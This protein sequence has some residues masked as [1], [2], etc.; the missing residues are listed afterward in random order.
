M[1]EVW[2]ARDTTLGRDVALK[3]LPD[4]L[5][6]DSDR[7]ARLKREAQILAS[8]NHPNIAAIHGFQDSDGVQ[9]LVLE[10]V[11][12]PTL[13]DRIA[14][15]PI[16]VDEALPIAKQI[17]EALEAAHEQGI[18][19]R[20]LKPANIK[21]RPDGTVK[22]LDFGLAKALE[23]AIS[24]MSPNVTQSPTI[25][26]PAMMT[27]AG[28]ILGTAAYMSPEQ[29]RGHAVDKRTDIW[30]FGCVLFEMV[31]G[32]RAFDGAS[33]T[34]IIASIIKTEPDWTRLPSRASSRTRS[35]L[36]HCLQ[37][38]PKRRLHEI[39]DARF[40]IDEI[41]AEEP[42]A[43]V[44]GAS[45]P[46]KRRGRRAALSVGAAAAVV[47][48]AAAAVVMFNVGGTREGDQPS[49][50]FQVDP[51]DG[52][53]FGIGTITGAT[54]VP[55]PALSP[56]GRYLA[57]IAI[58]EDRRQ[59]LWI[60]PLDSKLAQPVPGSEGAAVP[61]WSPD[62]RY[63]GFF[64]GR[65]LKTVPVSG[66]P[67]QT[68][69]D[70]IDD[71]GATGSWNQDNVIVFSSGTA[72]PGISRVPASGGQPVAITTLNSSREETGHL[73]PHF[74]PDGRHFLFFAQSRDI[75]A[76][77]HDGVYIGSLDAEEPKR[78]LNGAIEAYYAS[79]GYLLFKRDQN[80][81]A[82]PFDAGR[83]E[84]A[85]DAFS[86]ADQVAGNS[87]NGKVALSVSDAGIIAY[88]TGLSLIDRQITWL[89]RAG[90]RVGIVGPLGDYRAL[91]LSDDGKRLALTRLSDGSADIW[92]LDL[93]RGVPTRLTFDPAVD[94]APVW[95][96][97][98]S[99]VAFRSQRNEKTQLYQKLASG[100]GDDDP[101]PNVAG[102]AF[103]HDW[104]SD[105]RFIVYGTLGQGTG[106]DLWV[107]PLSG[108]QK[109]FGF[110]TT[111][112]SE[113]QARLSPDGRWL[114]YSSNESGR[115]EVY[116]QSFPK[117]AGKWQ[118]STDGGAQPRWRGDG[119]ELYYLS[120]TRVMAVPITA[121]AGL[122]VG[123]ATPLFDATFSTNPLRFGATEYDVAA[124]GQRF[125]VSA[126]T[127]ARNTPLT[128]VVNWTARLKN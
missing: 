116:V 92:L 46:A 98:G 109:P 5:A 74:L 19:H 34:D 7:L 78:I 95:S 71:S 81:M 124:D 24:A 108:D 36:R 49:Y 39:A 22:V 110:L 90:N 112:F 38:D 6:L 37:K 73:W 120:S 2:K 104:S 94:N 84:P 16:P 107:L 66:G 83:L 122:E 12:G 35:F 72:N 47:T 126:F 69:C 48:V 76:S 85:G 13:A 56:D 43:S 67:P 11:E 121:A 42:E 23:P 86:I 10:L 53:V 28:M 55:Y 118:I 128:I 79:P 54:A 60:R 32:H 1:G 119:K 14:Q 127:E 51:P 106:E 103:T 3:I 44:H 45:T 77:E 30:A 99:R 9:A 26:S 68:L 96:P 75:S 82:Q 4:H 27:G 123:S 105:G 25:T 40:E 21:L 113:T 65:K 62:S 64:A 88:R 50:E 100:V 17:A 114:A 15:G 70:V 93:A 59:L 125:I 87:A 61:F 20:D 57:F 58:G 63:V 115:I 117:P 52:G 102:I 31:T 41:L 97:D 80:L 29:A 101:L 89:D 33:A 111:P 91:E 18:I 8:L